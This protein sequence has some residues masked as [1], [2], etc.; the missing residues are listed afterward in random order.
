[1]ALL[2]VLYRYIKPNTVYFTVSLCSSLLLGAR[3]YCA[4]TLSSTLSA[5]VREHFFGVDIVDGHVYGENLLT[6]FSLLHSWVFSA[7]GECN[8]ALEH[9]SLILT[10][11]VTVRLPSWAEVAALFVLIAHLDQLAPTSAD[12]KSVW[13]DTDEFRADFEKAQKLLDQFWVE[14][15]CPDLYF[16]LGRMGTEFEKMCGAYMQQRGRLSLG[17]RVDTLTDRFSLRG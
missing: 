2:T 7:Q 1:M 3:F 15:E 17:V 8:I 12:G 13:H 4:D 11:F 6:L 14:F 9:P 16:E 10:P 5:V